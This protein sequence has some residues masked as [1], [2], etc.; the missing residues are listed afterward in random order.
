MERRWQAGG[1]GMTEEVAWGRG[2]K[3]AEG[4]QGVKVVVRSTRWSQI[5][6]VQTQA[7]PLTVSV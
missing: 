4:I 6:W 7:Q 5:M 3:A 2:G 1:L